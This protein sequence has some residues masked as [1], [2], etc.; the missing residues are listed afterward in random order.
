MNNKPW[1]VLALTKD[2]IL[3]PVVMDRFSTK[4]EAEMYKQKLTRLADGF[5]YKVVF[6]NEKLLIA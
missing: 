2:G 3:L 4:P 6:D 1:I 5:V